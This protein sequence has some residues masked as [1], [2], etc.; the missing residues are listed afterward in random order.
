MKNRHEVLP[1]FPGLGSLGAR[2]F[3]SVLSLGATRD[4]GT[5]DAFF[6]SFDNTREVSISL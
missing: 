1:S 2:S 3:G 4:S 5:T 6:L